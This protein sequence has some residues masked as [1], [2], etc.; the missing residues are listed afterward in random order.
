M[1]IHLPLYKIKIVNKFTKFL[2]LL[3]IFPLHICAQNVGDFH[4][5]GLVFYTDSSGHGLILD[6]TYLEATQDWGYNDPLLSEWGVHWFS[7][8]GTE[9]T[10]IGAGHF[11]TMNLA[12]DNSNHYAGN[13]CFNSNNGGYSDWFL[14]SK[15]ELLE[16]M[17][18]IN[19]IDSM[20]A[21]YGGRPIID[22]L[23]WSSTQGNNTSKAWSL[24][25]YATT[26]N[27]EPMGPFPLE[28]TKS[29]PALVRAVRCINNDCAFDGAPIFGC[30]DAIAENFNIN[31]GAEDLSCEYI[32]G[33]T[34]TSACNFDAEV[35]L[36]N[37][38]SCD[39]NC[40]GCTD[41]S[42][43]N[44]LGTEI[45][46]ED[47]SCLYCSDAYQTIHVSY[48]P[49]I[50]N[51]MF[52]Q[53]NNGDIALEHVTEE[54]FSLGLCLPDGC[55]NLYLFADCNITGD[56]VG[57]TIQIGAFSYT[58]DSAEASIDFYIGEG[59]CITG[60]TDD[61]FIEFD[62]DATLDDGSCLTPS[63]YGCIDTLACNW[64]SIA[65]QDDGSCSFPEEIYLDCTG[66]CLNDIDQDGECD[67]VDYNDGLS[68]KEKNNYRPQLVKM[69]DLSGREHKK[70]TQGTLLLY[71][72]ND[73]SSKKI[74]KP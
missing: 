15:D 64:N 30:T 8:P 40:I 37:S 3:S 19:L 46:I 36:N 4:Q 12:E 59:E 10:F 49:L 60:C 43:L 72:Y 25:P 42:A 67:E 24:S 48:D 28:W 20:V 53:I 31:A 56:W 17:L 44:Y 38:L 23:H 18:N 26:T 70:H 7:N 69:I 50:G 9:E 39:Y 45:T 65:N 71:M 66:N 22:A 11:N 55:Y 61:S 52:F 34:D 1:S 6:T 32:E 14:P 73:G 74:T 57:N 47:G 21:I 2:S 27:G 62:F 51:A 54:N 16:I 29:N 13:L 35:T 58:L 5:G 33:C 63:V 68:I 41:S